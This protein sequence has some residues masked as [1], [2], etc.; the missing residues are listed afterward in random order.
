MIKYD[1]EQMIKHLERGAVFYENTEDVKCDNIQELLFAQLLDYN[2]Y[3]VIYSEETIE[4]AIWTDI[5][6]LSDYSD[7]K[8][9]ADLE[10][11]SCFKSHVLVQAIDQIGTFNIACSTCGT[12]FEVELGCKKTLKM[13]DPRPKI[14]ICEYC[15]NVLDEKIDDYPSMS[16]EEKLI[17]DNYLYILH[18]A[19][20]VRKHWSGK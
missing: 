2:E 15:E 4:E 20:V 11:C 14:I 17:H 16:E 5:D 3:E 8:F 9:V 19:D 10:L 18:N 7:F 6:D 12:F 13:L 1:L